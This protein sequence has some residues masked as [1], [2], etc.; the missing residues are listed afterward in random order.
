MLFAHEFTVGSI[1]D[2]K[3]LSLIM[4]RRKYEEWALVTSTEEK[5]IAVLLSGLHSFK[6]FDCAGND[7]YKGLIVHDVQIEVDETTMFDPGYDDPP[8]GSA[9]RR[10]DV[11]GINCK[12]DGFIHRGTL[13]PMIRGLASTGEAAVGFRNWQITIRASQQKQVLWKSKDVSMAAE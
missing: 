10:L 6:F 7:S 3:P 8:H 11:L 13:V 1:A 12:S 5:S 2:A 4:P 9:I